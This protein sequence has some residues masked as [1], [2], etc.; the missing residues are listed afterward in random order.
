MK[1]KI[2]EECGIAF[3][4]RTSSDYCSAAC[5][6]WAR[7]DKIGGDDACWIWQGYVNPQNRYGYISSHLTG[8]NRTTVH[9]HAFRLHY[10]CDPGELH[11][12]HR[13]DVRLCANPKH[14][15]LGTPHDNWAD[16]V[17]KGRPIVSTPRLTTN[18]VVAIRRS[19]AKVR[20]LV[21]QFNVTSSTI[22]SVRRRE[23]WQHVI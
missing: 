3:Y 18:E 7:V 6:F 8:G 11:V 16:A 17:A 2:C 1:E 14:L 15:F 9:R 19:S 5:A 13:C 12:L 23:T 21:A 10:Q 4:G 20:E 22:Y